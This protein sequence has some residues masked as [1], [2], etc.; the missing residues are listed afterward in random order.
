M[1]IEAD[2]T[3]EQNPTSATVSSVR[4]WTRS[5]LGVDPGAHSE[6]SITE[7]IGGRIR[8]I[9]E[10]EFLGDWLVP[11]PSTE[12]RNT[13]MFSETIFKNNLV[14]VRSITNNTDSSV[15]K[16]TI[17]EL[18]RW[19]VPDLILLTHRR[20]ERIFEEST[21]AARIRHSTNWIEKLDRQYT[22]SLSAYDTRRPTTNPYWVADCAEWRDG[23]MDRLF[24]KDVTGS[25]NVRTALRV[26]GPPNVSATGMVGD[27]HVIPHQRVV[28]AFQAALDNTVPVG[29]RLRNDILSEFT[30]RLRG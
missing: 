7:F 25:L 29:T 24:M 9:F 27:V 2:T 14:A 15:F 1:A 8:N 6:T 22:V 18:V 11:G 5:Y 28:E 3:D 19:V 4:E 12:E 21:M 16:V 13:T 17:Y 26:F 30:G 20:L 23:G 10:S